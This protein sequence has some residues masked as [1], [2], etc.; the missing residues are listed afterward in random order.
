[1]SLAQVRTD[2]VTLLE[3]LVADGGEVLPYAPDA[4]NVFPCMWLADATAEIDMSMSLR[5]F[6]YTLPLTVAVA[7]K[8]VYGEERA[9][10]TSLLEEVIAQLDSNFT[11]GGTTFGLQA[12]QL[13]EGAIGPIGGETLVGF[14]LFLRI[15]QKLPLVLS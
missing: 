12:T 3:P 2:L 7:R 6:D 5:T 14:T 8:A 4:A 10:A 11:L 15:K 1:M 13:R 9:A